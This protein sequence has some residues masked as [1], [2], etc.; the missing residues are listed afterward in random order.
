MF[1]TRQ[2]PI[3]VCK[4]MHEI[5]LVLFIVALW[6]LT[7]TLSHA[8]KVDSNRMIDMQMAYFGDDM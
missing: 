8:F 4:R 1:S 2:N 3:R 7:E 6:F 5:L